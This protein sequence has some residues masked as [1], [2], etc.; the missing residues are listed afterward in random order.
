VA[1]GADDHRADDGCAVFIAAIAA[2]I[3]RALYFALV[4]VS[5]HGQAGVHFFTGKLYCPQLTPQLAADSL[6]VA[7]NS[8]DVNPLELHR[9]GIEECV[10]IRQPGEEV[11]GDFERHAIRQVAEHL[12]LEDIDAGLDHVAGGFIH[13]CLLLEG[14][15][16][17]SASFTTMS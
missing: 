1:A 16:P 5:R 10:V 11:R 14:A 7:V 8:A 15:H 12:G 13:S 2:H 3:A 6:P 17:P 9:E 4:P